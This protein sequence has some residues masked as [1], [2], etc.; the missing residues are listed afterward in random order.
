MAQISDHT[1]SGSEPLYSEYLPLVE[2]FLASGKEH[3]K[4]CDGVP[5]AVQTRLR[6]AIDHMR[7]KDRVRVSID[8]GDTYLTWR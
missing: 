4:V 2:R 1:S 5:K 6:S 7:A 3:I 8:S